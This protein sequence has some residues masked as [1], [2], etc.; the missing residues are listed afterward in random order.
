[1]NIEAMRTRTLPME[2]RAALRDKAARARLQAQGVDLTD[3]RD[4]K[5]VS[6]RSGGHGTTARRLQH[7]RDGEAACLDCLAAEH[8]ARYPQGAEQPFG[9]RLER[10]KQ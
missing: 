9:W 7:W 2:R 4:D 5:V 8:A 6:F 3:L 1:M 10:E